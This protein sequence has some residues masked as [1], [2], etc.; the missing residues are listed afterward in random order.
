MWACRLQQQIICDWIILNIP[1]LL[2]VDNVFNAHDLA[3]IWRGGKSSTLEMTVAKTVKSSLFPCEQKLQVNSSDG[4][5]VM[6][7]MHMSRPML[8]VLIILNIY[9]CVY[10]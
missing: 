10:I 7:L 3:L 1:I 6:T 5:A 9:M 2:Q 4:S 8:W